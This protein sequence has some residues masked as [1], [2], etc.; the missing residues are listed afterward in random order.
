M[1]LNCCVAD[2]E[3]GAESDTCTVKF[4]TPVVVGVPEIIPVLA[5]SASPEGKLP[6]VT[7]HESGGVPPLACNAALYGDPTAPT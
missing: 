6:D 2:W 4:D 3:V 5:L 1:M 7:D